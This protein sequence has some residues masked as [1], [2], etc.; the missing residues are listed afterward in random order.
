MLLPAEASS[1]IQRLDNKRTG[2]TR[3]KPVITGDT[4]ILEYTLGPS[5]L[6][7][8]VNRSRGVE[9]LRLRNSCY[10]TT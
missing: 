4:S 1:G 8:G 3:G 7:I 5:R 10:V 9:S 2:R 6:V